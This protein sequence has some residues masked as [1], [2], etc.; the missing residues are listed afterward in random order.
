MAIQP[1]CSDT[2]ASGPMA[3]GEAEIL[4]SRPIRRQV[5]GGDCFRMDALALEQLSQQ[6]ERGVLV[7]PLLD[8]NIENL[9][10]VVDGAP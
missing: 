5:V 1:K 8:Q 4:Q 3:I 10:L 7:A 9:T 6:L 2:H